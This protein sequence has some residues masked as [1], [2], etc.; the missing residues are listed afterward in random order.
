[1]KAVVFLREV[2]IL[3]C[4]L[5]VRLLLLVFTVVR[6]SVKRFSKLMLLVCVL[7]IVFVGGGQTGMPSYKLKMA[8]AGMIF[9][10]LS[11]STD[12]IQIGLETLDQKL[13]Y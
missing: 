9:L 11:W 6:Q 5:I 2:M 1:M 8:V 4:S 13:S 12:W 3:L 10:M 7:S